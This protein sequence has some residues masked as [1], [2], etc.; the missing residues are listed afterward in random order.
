MKNKPKPSLHQQANGF[1]FKRAK[2]LRRKTTPAEDALWHRLRA[3]AF[4]NLKFR[5]QHPIG[6]YIADFY[7]HALQLV[8]EVDGGIILLKLNNRKIIFGMKK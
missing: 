4:L 8:I 3:K 7:C 2:E 6:K 1:L 5:Q